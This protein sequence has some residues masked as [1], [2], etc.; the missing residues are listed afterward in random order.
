MHKR[1]IINKLIPADDLHWSES[2][3][4]YNAL[5]DEEVQQIIN[6]CYNKKGIV[7]EDLITKIVNWASN[8]QVSNVLLKNFFQNNIE[9]TGFVETE[10]VDEPLWGEKNEYK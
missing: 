1:S 2:D 10:L 3:E 7:E 4:K 5:S 6:F 8:V 9:I